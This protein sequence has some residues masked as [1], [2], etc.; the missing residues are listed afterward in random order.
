MEVQV[1]TK[2]TITLVMDLEEYEETFRVL[3]AASGSEELGA[4]EM[5]LMN[6][7]IDKLRGG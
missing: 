4:D 7:F 6:D 2:V 3:R 5:D 1:D